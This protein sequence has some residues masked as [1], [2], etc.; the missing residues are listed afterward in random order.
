MPAN[1]PAIPTFVQGTEPFEN[2]GERLNLYFKVA[3]TKET[4][5]V[6]V[7]SITL[8]QETYA[9]TLVLAEDAASIHLS[10]VDSS[11]S[12]TGRHQSERGTNTN[13]DETRAPVCLQLW[14]PS[15][16]RQLSSTEELYKNK[17]GANALTPFPGKLRTANGI[18]LQISG[19]VP[20]SVTDEVLRSLYKLSLLVARD[21][22]APAL[23][24]R[25]WL[26]ALR[27]VVPKKSRQV[28]RL[29]MD[30]KTTVNP[31]LR[32]DQ[33]PLPRADDIFNKFVGCQAF[34]HLDL[35]QAYLQLEVEE[36][37][38]ELL[39]IKTR[40]GLYRFNRLV[41]GLASAPAIFQSVIESILFKI[42]NLAAFL[43]D[44]LIGGKDRQECGK[45]L[46]LVLEKSAQTPPQPVTKKVVP[47][48]W[49]PECEL[50]FNKS[51]IVLP[52]KV[53]LVV[54]DP[55]K[56]IVLHVDSSGYGVGAVL[57]HVIDG[58]VC[59]I[60]FESAML[61]TTQRNYSQ[62]DKEALAVILGV[63][64]LHTYLYGQPFTIVRDHQPLMS[65][66]S[67]TKN[68]PHMASSRILH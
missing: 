18:G 46:N 32:V 19:V 29:C 37:C 6:A 21:L 41:F 47:L 8:P 51:K 31:H 45:N 33:Y 7:L 23:L 60:T 28:R 3:D 68:L 40:N 42:G 35:T 2:Y 55:T 15:S 66:F 52:K 65:L 1:G 20:V 64:K 27:P 61:T 44:I 67:E 57:S 34:C 30:L 22:S 54:F 43:D 38:R 26:S 48:I 4:D 13:V 5:N 16:V 14:G 12:L 59:P 53:L 17:P 25:N 58:I 56:D 24:D 11:V 49:M 36:S 9:R 50:A 62:L 39:T 63:Q 10:G